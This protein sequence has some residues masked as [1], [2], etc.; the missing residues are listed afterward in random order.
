ME[1]CDRFYGDNLDAMFTDIDGHK[2]D[3]AVYFMPTGFLIYGAGITYASSEGV[4][5]SVV[6][7]LDEDELVEL[8]TD[9]EARANEVG[10]RVYTGA[11]TSYGDQVVRVHGGQ[12]V[13]IDEVQDEFF[14]KLLD[15]RVTGELGYISQD[16]FFFGDLFIGTLKTDDALYIITGCTDDARTES[17]L[18]E[19]ET[20]GIETREGISQEAMAVL[21]ALNGRGG[22]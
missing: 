2:S 22:A 12:L 7:P 18:K 14:G 1:I 3:D 15:D 13:D 5:S 16:T 20:H 9:V 4:Y 8:G 11:V 19:A 6:A 21:E 10:L 17:F